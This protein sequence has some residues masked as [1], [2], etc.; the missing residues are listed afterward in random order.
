MQY[1]HINTYENHLV[2]VEG[3]LGDDP[4]PKF[5]THINLK[6]PYL[7]WDGV[8]KN[9]IYFHDLHVSIVSK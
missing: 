3:K 5:N 4:I 7:R 1:L 8:F 6:P 2:L 9:S